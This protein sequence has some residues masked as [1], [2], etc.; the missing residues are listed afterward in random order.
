MQ[1]DQDFKPEVIFQAVKLVALGIPM[2]RVG[3]RFGVP[4]YRVRF[5][6]IRY[7]ELT[8]DQLKRETEKHRPG[9]PRKDP[10]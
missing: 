7:S 2:S 6:A 5:W 10:S 3:R 4:H 1:T 9:R 8:L